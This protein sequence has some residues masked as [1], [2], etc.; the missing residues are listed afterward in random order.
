MVNGPDKT[1]TIRL[2][3]D[4]RLTPALRGVAREFTALNTVVNTASRG[5][6]NSARAVTGITT[7]GTAAA[8]SAAAVSDLGK[9]G[10][11]LSAIERRIA[12]VNG[13]LNKMGDAAE[14][15]A[16]KYERLSTIGRRMMLIGTG[17][18]VGIGIATKA[19]ADFDAEMSRVN[20]NVE[21]DDADLARRGEILAGLRKAA[22][23]ASTSTTYSAKEAAIAMTE[24][25]KAGVSAND[26]QMGG[27]KGA[28]DLAASG[29]LNV[30]EAAEIAAT[31]MV[32]FNKAGSSVPH[33]ADLLSAGANNAQGSVHDMGFAFRQAGLQANA[34]GLSLEDTAGTLTVFARAGLIGSD[35]GTSLKTMLQRM[36]PESEKAAKTIKELG[37]EAYDANGQFVGITEYAGKLQEKMRDLTPEARNA[38]MAIVFGQDAVR[39]ANILFQQGAGGIQEWIDKTNEAGFAARNAA[40]LQDNLTGD[41]KKLKAAVTSVA[42]EGSGGLY[43]FF[44]DSAQAAKALVEVVTQLPAPV[45]QAGAAFTAYMGVVTLLRGAATRLV[46]PFAGARAALATF[47]EEVR[48][49]QGPTEKAISSYR[50]LG[51]STTQATAAAAANA[52]KVGYLTAA[53]RA[54]GGGAGALKMAMGGL[55][56]ALGGPWGIAIMAATAAI[57]FFAHKTAEAKAR[58]EE[59]KAATQ[60]MTETLVANNGAWDMNA[61]KQLV[62]LASQK[63]I[64]GNLR[65]IGFSTEQA[66]QALVSEGTARDTV[67]GQTRARIELLKQEGQVIDQT[68]GQIYQSNQKQIDYYQQVYDNTLAVIQV[69]SEAAAQATLQAEANLK[70]EQA[71]S[72]AAG[73]TNDMGEAIAES[74]QAAK[75]AQE[76]LLGFADAITGGRNNQAAYEETIDELTEKMGALSGAVTKGGEDF[77]V[78]SEKG[79]N[80]QAMLL[81]LGNAGRD[82]ALSQIDLGKSADV[83]Q[84]Q[85]EKAREKFITSARALGLNKDA[86][87]ELATQLGLTNE[88]VRNHAAELGRIPPNVSTK[89]GVTGLDDLQS[90]LRQSVTL[91]QQLANGTTARVRYVRAGRSSVGGSTINADGAVYSTVTPARA[92]KAFAQGGI[93]RHEA[94]IAR[95]GAWRLWA[96]PET[97]GEAYLPLAPSKR[98]RSVQILEEVARRFGMS[99]VKFAEGGITRYASGGVTVPVQGSG[100]SWNP[101]SKTIVPVTAE[102]VAITLRKGTKV[103]FLYTPGGEWD[104]ST[105]RPGMNTSGVTKRY[106]ELYVTKEELTEAARKHYEAR[107]ALADNTV[108]MAEKTSKAASTAERSLA[109]AEAALKSAEVNLARVKKN[110]K[111]T[112]DQVRAAELRVDAARKRVNDARKKRQQTSSD[113]RAFDSTPSASGSVSGGGGRSA[114]ALKSQARAAGRQAGAVAVE[115]T[116]AYVGGA[117]DTVKRRTD[118]TTARSAALMNALSMNN[119]GSYV[120]G[121]GHQ[122]GYYKN[123]AALAADCSGF[124][125]WAIGHA[126]GRN[127]TGKSTAMLKGGSLGYVRIDPKIAAETAGALM[128]RAGHVVMS[129]G[130]GRVIESYSKGKPVR[131]RKLAKRDYQMA[132]WNTALGP[133]T[134]GTA[135]EITGGAT[136]TA[137]AGSANDEIRIRKLQKDLAEAEKDYKEMLRRYNTPAYVHLAQATKAQNKD[138]STFLIHIRKIR[139]RGYPSLAYRLLELGDEQA[140]SMAAS[141]V[142]A[143]DKVLRQ[144]RDMFEQNAKLTEQQSKL[145]ESLSKV[146]GPPAYVTAAKEGKEA[147]AKRRQWMD[148]LAKIYKTDPYL[149][150][151]LHAEGMETSFDLVMSV[152]DKKAA[153]MRYIRNY[154]YRDPA[155]LDEQDKALESKLA[156]PKWQTSMSEIRKKV[157]ASQKFMAALETL[158]KNGYTDLA[159]RYYDM[160]EETAMDEA[161]S[162]A[163]AS[164]AER[165]QMR[166]MYATQDAADKK[167]TDLGNLLKD[168]G[169]VVDVAVGVATASDP[170]VRYLTQAPVDARGPSMQLWSSMQQSTQQPRQN[171]PLFNVENMVAADPKSAVVDMET[172][173]G[174]MLSTTNLGGMV[175]M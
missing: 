81:D 29:Q 168:I 157:G 84:A 142:T 39:G 37:I 161:V 144:Q 23:E 154:R 80:A 166:K 115:T 59:L 22:I 15:A 16:D 50:A 152:K 111:A 71:A 70:L 99:V 54:A 124:V 165:E 51:M 156:G 88:A 42:I 133:M 123:D 27:L 25:A 92:V 139:D 32:Q 75:D 40:I 89:I 10:D 45:L 117:K 160:G 68:T 33:I 118:P 110:R 122:S 4:D 146:A 100:G 48:A 34:T 108:K 97:G 153:D 113:A 105:T 86:A 129:L 44:R 78:T 126:L 162:M 58:Q 164:N 136:G 96:E 143:P 20:A 26:I 9:Q 53:F 31:A 56:A 148:G 125:G 151:Q 169:K 64:I 102:V 107:Q 158:R 150:Q 76:A 149:A 19:L 24:L 52:P 106:D 132:S 159:R 36:T 134:K 5:M 38:A 131:I 8:K 55:T 66:T 127:A 83:S 170:S 73:G 120:F 103:P 174:D 47:N 65:N 63:N 147:N 77:D 145:S 93:E 82:A 172:Q 62:N 49:Q 30:A 137:V 18:A 69:G 140:A 7:V 95:A 14:A 104:R 90:G 3:A 85:M 17:M 141:L 163:S 43:A 79:R 91:M 2:E 114:S 1:V 11:K 35:A 98:A 46:G 28:L 175:N 67:L 41:L 21:I 61:S 155:A 74:A 101:V 6:A 112:R 57:G 116:K 12:P 128:G 173:L 171:V 13:L 135:A 87:G 119:R 60:A 121:G 130:D 138:Q 167:W 72:A 109:T 94:Q